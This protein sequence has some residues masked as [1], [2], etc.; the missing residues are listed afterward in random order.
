MTQMMRKSTVSLNY[1][2]PGKASKIK[3]FMSVFSSCVSDFIELLW[4][5]ERFSGSFVEKA[6]LDQVQTSLTARAKQSAA[7][8]ALHI[9]KSQRK[10]KRKA[11][12]TFYGKSIELDS[13]FVKVTESLSLSSSFDLWIRLGIGKRCFVFL[14]TKKHKQFMRFANDGWSLKQSGRL[15]IREDGKLFLDL[16]FV[17]EAPEPKITGHIIGLDCG[18][19]KL[20]VLTTGQIIGDALISK[21][22]KI[23]RKVQGS[24]A[25]K[26]A[27][28]ERNEYINRELKDL[29]ISDVSI[30]VVEALKYVKHKT[31]GKISTKFMNKLQ[32]WIY[33]Y[34]LNKLKSLCEVVG[35]QYHEVNPAYTSVTCSKCGDI[36]KENRN[37]EVFQCMRCGYTTDADYNASWN[38]LNRFLL[39]KPSD[40]V[41]KS[42]TGKPCVCQV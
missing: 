29:D 31:K 25:F 14:P 28:L 16:F 12:P 15:R 37:G 2:N 5:I 41:Q 3:E 20:A 17:K 38:I 7:Q 10:K 40:S 4:K 11:K 27:L 32:R 18:Y 1:S 22:E 8:T 24:K 23:S 36:H 42:F 6:I 21:I 9:V 35:V 33:S 19:K 39:Q 34:F 13:R 26:R 30:L